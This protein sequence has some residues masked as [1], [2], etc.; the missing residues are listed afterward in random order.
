VTTITSE[1]TNMMITPLTITTTT[2]ITI[3]IQSTVTATTSTIT[4]I[5]MADLSGKAIVGL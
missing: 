5:T 2:A 4:T 1:A 3:Q